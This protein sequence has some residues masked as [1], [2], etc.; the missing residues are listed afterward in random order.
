[1]ARKKRPAGAFR[2]AT[3]KMRNLYI[4]LNDCGLEKATFKEPVAAPFTAIRTTMLPRS[5]APAA[6]RLFLELEGL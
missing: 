1:L 3:G 4:D 5:S 6:R 2:E